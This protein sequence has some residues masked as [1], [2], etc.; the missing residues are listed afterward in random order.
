MLISRPG[1]YRPDKLRSRDILEAGFLHHVFK[2]RARARFY[3]ALF[4]RFEEFAVEFVQSLVRGE[5]TI[6][7]CQGEVVFN[8]LNQPS[9]FYVPREPTMSVE[10]REMGRPRGSGR[11]YSRHWPSNLGQS[12]MPLPMNR[13]WM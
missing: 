1:P 6:R 11:D 13:Q 3:T 12:L 7:R 2:K 5:R 10:I 8:A 9:W 4:R